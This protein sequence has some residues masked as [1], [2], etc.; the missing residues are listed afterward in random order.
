MDQ[1]KKKI[2]G[3]A[4]G[5]LLR[6]TFPFYEETSTKLSRSSKRLKKAGLRCKKIVKTQKQPF[7]DVLENSTNF[8]GNHLWRSLFLIKLQPWVCNFV[9]K[10]LHHRCFPAKFFKNT[11]FTKHLLF[12]KSSKSIIN[13]IIASEFFQLK[14]LPLSRNFEI[15]LHQD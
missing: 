13:F 8:T 6:Q 10:R 9:K 2:G 12:L 15:Q 3:C 11:F 7:A 5:I 4:V 1:K 14:K